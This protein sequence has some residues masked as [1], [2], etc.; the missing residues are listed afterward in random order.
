MKGLRVEIDF[1]EHHYEATCWMTACIILH[2]IVLDVEGK[3]FL[4]YLLDD[5]SNNSDEDVNDEGIPPGGNEDEV[6]GEVLRKLLVAEL[7]AY[8]VT[9]GRD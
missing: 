9:C 6:Q 4:I 3:E 1:K 5:E 8:R 7:M 2:N